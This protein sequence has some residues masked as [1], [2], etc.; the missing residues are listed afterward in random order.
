[1]WRQTLRGAS[2][3]TGGARSARPGQGLAGSTVRARTL[4][5]RPRTPVPRADS[6]QGPAGG[7]F[8]S[9]LRP[10]PPRWGSRALVSPAGLAP[11]RPAA[12]LAGAAGAGGTQ[13][14]GAAGG[15]GTRTSGSAE[16]GGGGL[17]AAVPA[18]PVQRQNLKIAVTSQT[19]RGR[20]SPGPHPREAQG[21]LGL[22]VQPPG[23][24][25]VGWGATG[26]RGPPSAKASGWGVGA[27]LVLH[28]RGLRLRP[29]GATAGRGLA[30]WPG[31]DREA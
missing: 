16:E 25:R 17:A 30:S 7:G 23:V 18:P 8:A 2:A 27:R 5:P 19:A 29:V 20:G 31:K 3:A 28:T 14:R 12:C 10:A 13:P 1:M 15:G 11:E 26:T 9:R 22:G 4:V 24:P 6:H 21:F